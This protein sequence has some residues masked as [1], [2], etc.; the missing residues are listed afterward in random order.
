MS[1]LSGLWTGAK[2]LFGL[3]SGSGKGVDNVMAVAKGVGGYIDEQKFTPQEQSEFNVKLI[4][5]MDSSMANTVSENTE[6]SKARREIALLVMR[7]ALAMLTIS[8]ILH[9]CGWTEDAKFIR[10]LVI[11][12]PIGYFVLGIGAFFFGAHIVRAM[13]EGK[14]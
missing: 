14:E 1:V 5:H 6:R 13:R 9:L 8:G 7:W 12:D 3:G 2:V 11:D 10:D 4:G